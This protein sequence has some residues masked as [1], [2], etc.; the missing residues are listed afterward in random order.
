VARKTLACVPLLVLALGAS[1]A[2]ASHD[3]STVAGTGTAG[4]TGDNGP[5]NQAEIGVPV[6]VKVVSDG[7]YLIFAQSGGVVRRVS[8]F[9]VIT[10]V[11]GN[12]T[13]GNGAGD[14]G[15][16]TSATMNIPS[17]GDMTADGGYLIA[18]ANDNR[19]RRVSPSG[20]ISTAVGNGGASFSGD[21]GPAGQATLSFPYDVAA[22]SDGGYLI[23]DE[24]NQRIRRVAADGTIST[25]AGGG[26]PPDGVGDGGPATS[27]QLFKPSG[28]TL[29]PDGGYLIADAYHNRVRKVSFD[30]TITTVAGTGT[31]GAT[32]DGGPATLATL[33]HPSRVA[34]E[35]DGGFIIADNLNH[36]VRRV[37]PDGTITT[38]AGTGTAGFN[39]D[40]IPATTA[41]LNNLF[42]VAVTQAGDYLVAD[43]NNQRIRL[44]DANPPAPAV[45]STSPPSPA[46]NN[47]PKVIGTSAIGTTVNVFSTADCSGTPVGSGSAAAFAKPGIAVSVPDNSTTTFHATAVDGTGNSSPC[48]TSSASYTEKTLPPPV[49]GESVNA[50]PEKGSVK[51]KVPG[52]A[53]F[54]QLEKLGRHLPVGSTVDATNGTVRLASAKDKAGHEQVGHFSEGAFKI[55]Q[56][57]KEALTTLSLTGGGLSSCG[58]KLPPGGSAKVTAARKKRRKLFSNV[59]GHFRTRGR[60]SAATVRGTEWRVT[61]TCAG[62]KTEVKR[63]SVTVEDLV[64]KKTVVVKKGHSYFA[65]AP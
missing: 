18:D 23:A 58:K 38:V 3:I 14:G 44:V 37:A 57:K 34:I 42:G 60:N 55:Q 27:A 17:G 59:K 53:G 56:K 4:E 46:D 63:G 61:D 16:A 35:P 62:T 1:P 39:G 6:G 65:K 15:P 50:K 22:Q 47:A 30:G 51:V 5:A 40:G 33:D 52:S 64:A 20:I 11:A 54:V 19:I 8:P 9:G 48:S 31:A 41:Q 2:A 32:G 36:E 7:G 24:D 49:R 28:V 25:V 12:G 21:G 10:T 26:S 29:T 43:T 13:S 45:T